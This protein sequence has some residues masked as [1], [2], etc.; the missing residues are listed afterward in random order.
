MYDNT[1][2]RN[3]ILFLLALTLAI[4]GCANFL[5]IKPAGEVIPSTAEDYASLLH[6]IIYAI[7]HD[8]DPCVIGNVRST[9]NF[10]TMTDNFE[11]A[12]AKPQ[13]SLSFFLGSLVS[14]SYATRDSY[15]ILYQRIAQANIIIDKTPKEDSPLYTSLLTAAHTLRAICYYQLMRLYCEPPVQGKWEQQLGVPMVMHVELEEKKTR[16]TLA[17]LIAAIETDL[18]TAITLGA[19]NK[20]FLFTA[21]VARAYLARHYF[22]SQQW[23]KAIPV[24]E[25]LLQKY[26][27]ANGAAN[28]NSSQTP[29]ADPNLLLKANIYATA[30]QAQQRIRDYAAAPLSREF[31]DLF[32]NNPQ[33][34]SRYQLSVSKLRTANKYATPCLRLAEMLL[35]AAEAH[36][37]LGNDA[38]AITHLNTLRLARIQQ[39]TPL[40]KATLPPVTKGL[41]THDAQG[42]ELT[43][44][45]SSILN[46]RRKELFMEGDRFFELK[47][48]G[49][50]ARAFAFN[51]YWYQ[52]EPFM[53]TFPIPPTDIY[54]QGPSLKQN[55]GYDQY[56]IG[57]PTS[58][59]TVTP[60]LA[61]TSAL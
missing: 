37:H 19:N 12:L 32:G 42:K 27:P 49:R 38:E 46:E 11:P 52:V 55:P 36:A 43:P 28:T 35:I 25:E 60:P 15:G 2:T 14:V 44:L 31:V 47:R 7:E 34:D 29:E 33:Q 45:I 54:I 56:T 61:P 4:T 3:K 1:M 20:D 48:N 58:N 6:N 8:D 41:I 50:P 39:A 51:G 59:N 40:T 23:A 24:A 5:D 13:A 26:T 53:Y 18:R 57:L 10:D 22:W 17:Q 21:N 9:E 16:G 30:D